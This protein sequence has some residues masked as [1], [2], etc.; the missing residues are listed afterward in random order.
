MPTF[1]SIKRGLLTILWQDN[2]SRYSFLAT[3]FLGISTLSLLAVFWNKLP[4]EVP[5]LFSHPWGEEQLA[6]SSNLVLIPASIFAIMFLNLFL[7]SL[8][9]NEKLAFRILLVGSSLYALL[10]ILALIKILQ[11][12]V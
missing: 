12:S 6:P 9:F 8:F 3:F 5:L 7:G 10:Q 2:L 4:P 11:L 1:S